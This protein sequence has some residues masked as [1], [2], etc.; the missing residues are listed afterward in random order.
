MQIAILA[1]ELGRG[2]S[3]RKARCFRASNRVTLP[4]FLT[5]H[6]SEA[7]DKQNFLRRSFFTPR[8]SSVTFSFEAG[9]VRDGMA[10]RLFAR[11]KLLIR[12]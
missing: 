10:R 8:P 6:V 9:V 7:R 5:G 1:L 4:K 12:R 3:I 2:G 11:A